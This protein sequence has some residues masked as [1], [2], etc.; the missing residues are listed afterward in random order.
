MTSANRFDPDTVT[1]NAGETVAWQNSATSA[2]TATFNPAAV[3]PL[4]APSVSLPD[5]V[6]PF[7]SGDL[8]PGRTW[9]HTFTATGTYKYICIRH[10]SLGEHGTVVVN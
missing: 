4:A 10:A 7:D 8:E 6:A 3:S 9:T 1:I 5:G 2:H